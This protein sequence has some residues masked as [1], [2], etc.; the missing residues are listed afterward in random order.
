MV[1]NEQECDIL[2]SKVELHRHYFKI[3]TLDKG[4]KLFIPTPSY[5]LNSTTAIVYKDGFGI[6]LDHEGW[7]AFWSNTTNISIL[8]NIH[9]LLSRPSLCKQGK[10]LLENIIILT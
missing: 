5:W 9:I 7:Y 1:A 3:N 10:C 8:A 4:M 2:V 6:E